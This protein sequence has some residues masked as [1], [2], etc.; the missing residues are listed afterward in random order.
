MAG[1]GKLTE[2]IRDWYEHSPKAKRAY[3]RLSADLDTVAARVESAT[4]G[5]RERVSPHIDPPTTAQETE[6]GS[7]APDRPG[8]EPR[9]ERTVGADPTPGPTFARST[10]PSVP[11]A[12]KPE[13]KA[14]AERAVDADGGPAS[15]SARPP[16]DGPA[17]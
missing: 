7:P 10:E 5:L 16:S 15:P 13:S 17:S 8:P 14:R 11:T 9:A 3:R 6:T 1:T 12:E 4:S 2:Q